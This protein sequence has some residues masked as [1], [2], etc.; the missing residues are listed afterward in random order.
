[1]VFPPSP[2]VFFPRF[3]NDPIFFIILVQTRGEKRSILDILTWSLSSPEGG[4]G[5]KTCAWPRHGF[6]SQI[7]CRHICQQL[8]IDPHSDVQRAPLEDVGVGF[9]LS[10]NGGNVLPSSS[11]VQGDW[12]P[13]LQVDTTVFRRRFASVACLLWGFLKLNI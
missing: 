5:R 12:P 8:L 3:V 4:I 2:R 9:L 13:Y 7:D 11:F 6:L 1:M 10:E